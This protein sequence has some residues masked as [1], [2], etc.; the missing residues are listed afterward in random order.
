MLKDYLLIFYVITTSVVSVSGE[1]PDD[2]VDRF[3]ANPQEFPTLKIPT[4]QFISVAQADE[5]L[6][7]E[8]KI[9]DKDEEV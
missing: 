4:Q 8:F 3:R 6:T 1:S 9:L 2:A 5:L 7:S